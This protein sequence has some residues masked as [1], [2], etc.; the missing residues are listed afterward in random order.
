MH[1]KF[2]KSSQILLIKCEEFHIFADK[3]TLSLN[4]ADNNI[5]N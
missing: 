5:E 2:K 4:P 1:E 3:Q